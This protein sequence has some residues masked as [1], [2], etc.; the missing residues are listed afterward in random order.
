[1]PPEPERPELLESFSFYNLQKSFYADN[2]G[3]RVP[4]FNAGFADDTPLLNLQ[5][6]HTVLCKT[7]ILEAPCE[8]C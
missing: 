1:M 2:S 8:P 7:L 3:D 4:R 6:S 5:L